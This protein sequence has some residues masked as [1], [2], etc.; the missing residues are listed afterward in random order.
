MGQFKLVV[1]DQSASLT[2]FG[3]SFGDNGGN[4]PTVISVARFLPSFTFF[5]LFTGHAEISA[6]HF[7]SLFFF[8]QPPPPASMAPFPNCSRGRLWMTNIGQAKKR[9]LTI[10]STIF[11]SVREQIRIWR[12]WIEMDLRDWQRNVK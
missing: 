2:C 9:K 8:F 12:E 1:E 6:R 10:M 5:S 3:Y 4:E 11:R 7:K